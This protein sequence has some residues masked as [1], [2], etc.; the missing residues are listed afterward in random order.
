MRYE[1]T[2]LV[3]SEIQHALLS[4]LTRVSFRLTFLYLSFESFD[5]NEHTWKDLVDVLRVH[6][7]TIESLYLFISPPRTY[8]K[9]PFEHVQYVHMPQL[10]KLRIS[11]V[12]NTTLPLLDHLLQTSTELCDLH[13][14]FQPEFRPTLEK[15]LEQLLTLPDNVRNFSIAECTHSDVQFL[16]PALRTRALRQLAIHDLRFGVEVEVAALSLTSLPYNP[17]T[18]V[19]LDLSCNYQHFFTED[20]VVLA[21]A[22]SAHYH[23]L[24]ELILTR[25]DMAKGSLITIVEALSERAAKDKQRFCLRR[26]D[27]FQRTMLLNSTEQEFDRPQCQMLWDGV[28]KELLMSKEVR[29]LLEV[30]PSLVWFRPC[31]VFVKEDTT[32]SLLQRNQRHAWAWANVCLFLACARVASP[33]LRFSILPLLP[34]IIRDANG[35]GDLAFLRTSNHPTLPAPGW[36]SIVFPKTEGIDG[37]TPLYLLPLDLP[38]L[39]EIFNV[40]SIIHTRY[41]QSFFNICGCNVRKRKAVL[42]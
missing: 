2:W 10:S 18:L 40:Q 8:S 9:V 30:A 37:E 31:W 1:K 27:L 17:S 25:T 38:S 3:S 19:S 13:V 41:G 20:V 5:M 16:A 42:L 14:R 11:L 29:H 7:P 32:S 15:L 26:L 24:T 12:P 4:T 22:L 21:A 36:P 28:N 33:L 34:S 23:T 35:S 6:G 39:A